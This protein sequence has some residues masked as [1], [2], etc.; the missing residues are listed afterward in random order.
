MLLEEQ[1]GLAPERLPQVVVE[2]REQRRVRRDGSCRLR[3]YSH[4]PAKL[5]TSASARGSASMRRTCCSSTAGVV[6][7][8]L[9]GQRQQLV[10]RNAAPEEERQPRRELEI[11]DAVGAARRDAGRLALDAEEE[12]RARPGCAAAPISMPRVERRRPRG[13]ARRTSSSACR[14]SSVDRPP[15]GAPR[16][17]RQDLS[18]R[19]ASSSARRRPAGEDPLGGSACRR[20]PTRRTAR[21]LARCRC[22]DRTCSPAN[23][24]SRSCCARTRDSCRGPARSWLRGT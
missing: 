4:W 9:L 2:I 6:Q 11:A 22:A 14:S 3:R 15:I 7:L 19:T 24:R 23:R 17:R 20:R 21:R 12:L 10:V 18:A 1:L 13:P 8:A 5:L 16:Q